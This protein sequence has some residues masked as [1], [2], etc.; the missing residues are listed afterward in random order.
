M[1]I[2]HPAVAD[3]SAVS[4]TGR[5]WYSAAFGAF[6]L[7]AGAS[8]LLGIYEFRGTV[9]LLLVA[10]GGESRL[11]VPLPLIRESLVVAV[12]AAEVAVGTGLLLFCANPRLPAAFAAGLL[13]AFSVVLGFM[14]RMDDPPSCGCL[15]SWDVLKGEAR[16]GAF[17]GLL[18]NAGLLVLAGWLTLPRGS[19]NPPLARASRSRAGFTLVELLVILVI[20]AVLI[21][22]LLPALGKAK[23]LGKGTAVLSALRQANAAIAQYADG[24][25]GYLPYL[26]TPGNPDAG[27]WPH[28]DWGE[29]GRPTYFGG[30]M[31]LWPSVLVGHGIDLSRLPHFTRR[32]EGPVRIHTYFWMTH[33]A[34]ARPEYWVGDDPPDSMRLFAGVRLDEALFPSD[35]GLLLVT[36]DLDGDSVSWPVAFCDGS[37]LG[38]SMTDPPSMVDGLLRRYGAIPWRVLTTPEGIRGR[39]Y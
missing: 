20:L 5:G 8:K 29:A 15:G 37:A 26:G 35:K 1:T 31:S 12:I 19:I 3:S 21:G 39:D 18:R 33:A 27:V 22:L 14:L 13:V 4:G 36:G 34:V 23:T 2:A 11:S 24:E 10:S 32:E 9:D 25:S 6:F 17:I 38:E 16:A 30:Q 28:E 7:F